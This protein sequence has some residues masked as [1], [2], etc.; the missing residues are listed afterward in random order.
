MM[1]HA[2]LGVEE[3]QVLGDLGDGGDRRFAGAARHALF[4]GHG[5]RNAAHAVKG[6]PGQLLHELP[7]VGR[8][9]LH[10]AP[11]ALGKHDVEGEGRF[12]R[13]GYTGDDVELP[14]RDRE[15]EVFEVVLA[16]AE[17]RQIAGAE[18]QR[19]LG[20]HGCLRHGQLV[21]VT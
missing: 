12:A 16:G 11:L 9:R 7:R 19:R 14:V 3:A 4:D 18:C 21:N 15:R 6:G 20:N 5:R 13:A 10:E 17:N 8:H 2:E 1:L